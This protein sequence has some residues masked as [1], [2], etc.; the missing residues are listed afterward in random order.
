MLDHAFDGFNRNRNQFVAI[1]RSAPG[2]CQRSFFRTVRWGW[3]PQCC[4]P[5]RSRGIRV[6]PG[7]LSSQLP[8]CMLASL[9]AFTLVAPLCSNAQ[10]QA[11]TPAPPSPNASK[12]VVQAVEPVTTTVVVQGEIK[13]DYLP[14]SVTVGTLDSVQLKDAPISAT[15][16]T[17]GLLNDQV[18]RL[19]S[20]VVKNDA[21]VGD[22]YVPVGYYGDYQIR[23]F[24]IDLATGFEI[25]GMT[26]AG[27]Q[28]VPL[29]NKEGVEILKGIAG[30]ER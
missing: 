4:H 20:D 17:R 25:N 26:I 27:E 12:P 3:L 13:D 22:D 28:D 30:V 2:A 8:Q 7:S 23:G 6:A 21:S 11:K 18:A 10:S 5:G 9:V 1:A 14:E 24:P 19:I 16:V 29:E 15:V